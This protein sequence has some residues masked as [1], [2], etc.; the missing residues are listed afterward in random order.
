MTEISIIIPVYKVEKY[1][2]ECLD[3]VLNQTFSDFECI[4]VDDGSPDGCGEICDDYKKKDSRI[5]VIHQ[6]N[7][8]LG[9]A[10]NEGMKIAKGKYICF[11]DSDDCLEE[12]YLEIMHAHA[13]KHNVDLVMCGYRLFFIDGDNEPR[14]NV[15]IH[16]KKQGIGNQRDIVF[17]LV[18]KDGY[19]T[20]IWNKLIRRECI[21]GDNDIIFFENIYGEDERWWMAITSRIQSVYFEPKILYNW[22]RHSESLCGINYYDNSVSKSLLETYENAKLRLNWLPNDEE[23]NMLARANFYSVGSTI[24][25]RSYLLGKKDLYKNTW[26]EIR[27]YRR[28]WLKIADNSFKGKAGR[29]IIDSLMRMSFPKEIVKQLIT[30]RSKK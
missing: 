16:A 3:S 13:I 24:C 18:C 14:R 11:V 9:P 25:E 23:I 30:L 21:Y 8:G 2:K 1:L 20:S 12:Q 7:Q 6:S 27:E 10:R 4:L 17:Q 15:D 26:I 22:R 5:T 19:F 29:I 28:M